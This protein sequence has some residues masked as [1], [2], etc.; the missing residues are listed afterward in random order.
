MMRW[1]VRRFGPA[2][3]RRAVR[4]PY[5]HLGSDDGLYMGR[6]WLVPYRKEQV[7]SFWRRPIGWVLQRFGVAVRIHLI[8]SADAARHLHDH[9]WAFV[10]VVLSGGY[11][12]ARP[13]DALHPTFYT[14]DDGD[15]E[16][17]THSCRRAGDVGFRRATDRHSIVRV[18]PDT[19]TLFITGPDRHWWGFY[20]QAGKVYFKDYDSGIGLL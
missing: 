5:R 19:Y 15:R 13:F 17:L 1:L 12:E 2:L 6:W 16:C 20:T 9:P 18:E 11:V 8:A 14:S 10:S 3:I 7:L 4:T